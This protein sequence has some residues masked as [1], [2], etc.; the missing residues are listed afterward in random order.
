[1][2][3]PRPTVEGDAGCSIICGLSRRTLDFSAIPTSSSTGR[4]PLLTNV[5]TAYV[6]G[7]V[8]ALRLHAATIPAGASILVE[9]LAVAPTW[10]D[11]AQDFLG[12]VVAAFELLPTA[13]APALFESPL[14]QRAVTHVS[15]YATA[16][17]GGTG[18]TFTAMVSLDLRA[19]EGGEPWT[20]RLLGAK[21]RL[22][23]DERDQVPVSGGVAEWWNQ[24]PAALPNLV[25]PT[26]SLRPAT[27]RIVNG[28]TAPSWVSADT[29]VC[30]AN[31]S[32][33]W[34]KNGGHLL[35]VVDTTGETLPSDQANVY[36]ETTL[37]AVNGAGWFGLG[38]TTSGPRGYAYDGAFQAT[39]RVSTTTGIRL[40]DFWLSNGTLSL[41][42]DAGTA[43]TIGGVGVLTAD[44]AAVW[45]GESYGGATSLKG[46][47]AAVLVCNE[48]LSTQEQDAAR[49]YL[50]SKYGVPA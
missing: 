50:S 47:V 17:R 45:T 28:L 41:R 22:W 42:I 24:V 7:A 46:R 43:V 3:P 32:D 44:N 19:I 10:E 38:W 4:I 33:F 34:T 14:G 12:P 30:V 13:V 8:A 49:L 35:M 1:M 11:P 6:T 48:A 15:I 20:P 16:T 37:L 25:Q 18:G 9:L 31:A 39:P 27:G 21:L 40:F 5:A 2:P 29:L 36:D 23:L 26:S